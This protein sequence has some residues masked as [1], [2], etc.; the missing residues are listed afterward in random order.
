MRVIS[1]I[2]YNKYLML[3]PL[4]SMI[5]LSGIFKPHHSSF[6]T[7]GIRKSLPRDFDDFHLGESFSET[8]KISSN[9]FNRNGRYLTLMCEENFYHEL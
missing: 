9:N 1:H 3:F 6:I 5:F 8:I 7:V 2:E 4:Y